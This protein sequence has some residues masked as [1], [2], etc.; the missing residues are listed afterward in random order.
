MKLGPK[1]KI[2]RRVGAPIFE[3][4]QTQKYAL[5][6]ERKSKTAKFSRPKSE[7]GSQLNEKQKA[8]LIYGLSEKQFSKYVKEA[9]QKKSAK[10]TQLIFEYLETRIDNIIYRLG[11][12]STRRGAR[13]MV[14]HGH[15]TVNGRRTTAPS[16][17]LFIG[18]TLSI[19]AGSLNKGLF[20][21]NENKNN[22]PAWL[23]FNFDK[24]TAVMTGMPV[25]IP[26]ENMF[27]LNAVVELYSR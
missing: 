3:K 26:T 1:Y 11:L 15:I 4:T 27:D 13:Q 2:A 24:K 7:F 5:R 19:R 8:R 12:S 20:K 17:R 18:D 23:D 16:Q 10:S 6:A 14:S 22:T 9:L 21:Q 25:L